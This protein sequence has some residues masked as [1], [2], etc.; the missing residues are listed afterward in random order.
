MKLLKPALYAVAGIL[1]SAA[2]IVMMTAAVSS[3]K[4]DEQKPVV[5]AFSAVPDVPQQISIA[6]EEYDL[7]RYD[8]RERFDRELTSF[9]YSH[10]LTLQ[11][12][13]RA[14][15]YFPIVEP[16]LKQEG[17]PADFLY[18]MAIESSL[19]QL[20]LSPVKAASFWQ[21]MPATAREYGLEVNDSI[22]E[23]YH[24]EK[25]TRAACRYM[26]KAYSKYGNWMAVAASYNGGQGRITRELAR[27]KADDVFSLWLTEETTR[28]PFRMMALKTIME[29]PYRYGFVVKSAQLYKPIRTTSVTIKTTI[30]D[31]VAFAAKHGISYREPKDFNPWLRGRSL[32]NKSGRTYELKIPVREDMIYSAKQKPVVYRKEWV[33]D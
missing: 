22:D 14:N 7:T 10:N 23:R 25:A 31:L 9:C 24:I 18:L 4:T 3:R 2:A 17:V 1:V 33:V 20:A 29:A 15:R 27:Q 8:M 5:M 12:I 13:K 30:P 11:I 19:N 6:G 21:L 16:I 28:Y 32:P 26:K